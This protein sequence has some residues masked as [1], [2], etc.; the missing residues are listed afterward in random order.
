MSFTAYQVMHLRHHKYLGDPRDPDDYHNYTNSQLVV[1]IMHFTRLVLGP[2]LYIFLIP[3]FAI[4]YESSTERRRIFAEYALLLSFY[5]SLLIAVPGYILFWAWIAPLLIVGFMTS[6]RGFTQHGLTDAH[7]PYLASRSIY[8]NRVITFFLLNENLHLE[9]HLFP[10]IPSYNLQALNELISDRLTRKV[11]G[12]SYLA[13]LGEFFK[14]T[15][16]MDES[17]VGLTSSQTDSVQKKA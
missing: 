11:T 17:P 14:R 16:N 8:P 13:F 6:I 10:E 5:A 15:L 2:L 9:H 12:K 4:K 1:W 3:I 7:D